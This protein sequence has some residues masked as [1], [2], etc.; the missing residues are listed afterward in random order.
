MDSASVIVLGSP[1]RAVELEEEDVRMDVVSTSDEALDESGS[2]V[3]A[4][5]GIVG[6][7][8]L[9]ELAVNKLGAV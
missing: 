1:V 5:V 6:W 3:P 2:A 7:S 9:T 4:R 8:C